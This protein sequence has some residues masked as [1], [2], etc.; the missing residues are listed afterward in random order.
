MTPADADQLPL[1]TQPGIG[2]VAEDENGKVIAGLE[3]YQVTMLGPLWIDPS[4]RGCSK[5]LLRLWEGM[6]DLLQGVEEVSV[7]VRGLPA[8]C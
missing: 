2:I 1:H 5:I 8:S 6:R 3:S 4:H 7:I